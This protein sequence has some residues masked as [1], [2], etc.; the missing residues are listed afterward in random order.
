ME[1]VRKKKFRLERRKRTLIELVGKCIRCEKDVYCT[2]GFLNGITVG[3]GNI[4]CFFCKDKDPLMEILF[5]LLSMELTN[6]VV[7]NDLEKIYNTNLRTLKKETEYICHELKKIIPYEGGEIHGVKTNTDT[8]NISVSI[9][10][11][12]KIHGNLVSKLDEALTIGM[13]IS[14]KNALLEI[15]KT[16]E[17]MLASI[18]ELK[19]F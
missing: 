11:L 1:H 4:L 6:L 16:S 18:G 3:K 14:T 19:E 5:D 2:D 15:K 7:I 9:E 10:Y 8:K 17:K 12:L 13:D